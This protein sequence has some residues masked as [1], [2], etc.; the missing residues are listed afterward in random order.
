VF[1]RKAN[2]IFKEWFRNRNVGMSTKFKWKLNRTVVEKFRVDHM[3]FY[4]WARC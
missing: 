3:G 1:G 4:K 2:Q